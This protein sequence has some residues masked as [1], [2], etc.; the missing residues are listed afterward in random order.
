MADDARRSPLGAL[1]DFIIIG[2][3][4]GGTT[5]LF[6]LLIRHPG[7]RRPTRKELHYFS[8]RYHRGLEWY[9][10][11]FPAPD[12]AGGR[13]TI[14]GEASPYYLFHPH[15]PKRVARA[16][17]RARLIALIRNPV[18]RAYSHYKMLANMGEELL[19]FEDALE[20]EPERLRGE[21]E[22]MLADERYASFNHQYFSY[23]SRGIYV[24]QLAR[25]AEHFE[26]E[27]MLVLKGEDFYERVPE[28]MRLVLDFLGLPEWEP[29]GR[30]IWKKGEYDQ[31]MHPSTRLRLEDYFEPH[32][33]RLYEYLGVDLGW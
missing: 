27:Q 20:A 32:N 28:T 11:C 9:R 10:D 19:S 29:E 4:K 17:P 13:E 18:D 6:R 3:Q 8:T 2:A 25:W 12:R 24:D 31:E 33:R 30:T 14:T 23:L 5:T 1:P 21:T 16:V 22:R 26:K 7:V 15:A